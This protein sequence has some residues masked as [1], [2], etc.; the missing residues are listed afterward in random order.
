[1]PLAPARFALS[2]IG[3]VGKSSFLG[4]LPYLAIIFRIEGDGG[5]GDGDRCL[6]GVTN[7]AL[8]LLIEVRFGGVLVVG[9][10]PLLGGKMSVLDVAPPL[11]DC[12]RR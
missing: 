7:E 10:W 5:R 3:A 9:V 1:M 4:L 6:G 12:C 11:R 2:A 8:P